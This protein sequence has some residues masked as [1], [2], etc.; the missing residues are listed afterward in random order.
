MSCPQKTIA[1]LIL[2]SCFTIMFLCYP[3]SDFFIILF[4]NP[5]PYHQRN[6][7]F[8]I[9]TEITLRY[10][11]FSLELSSEMEELL[12]WHKHAHTHNKFT[13]KELRK[14]FSSCKGRRR[15]GNLFNNV[16]EIA[17]EE[18]K[19]RSEMKQFFVCCLQH[20]YLFLLLLPFDKPSALTITRKCKTCAR[21]KKT[22]LALLSMQ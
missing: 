7:F 22:F 12:L 10:S 16:R 19:L 11:I 9:C 3:C 5:F 1:A 4:C 17:K 21:K 6:S 14:K 20:R 13:K 15:K 8:S 2:T 18:E